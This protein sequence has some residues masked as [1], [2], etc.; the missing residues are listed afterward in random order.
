MQLKKTQ[1]HMFVWGLLMASQKYCNAFLDALNRKEVPIETTPQE[2]LSLMGVEGSLH[3]LIAFPMKISLP[4]E[5]LTLD[6]C[7]SPLNA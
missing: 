2:V 4:K 7:K 6:P 3:P 5:R 1:A